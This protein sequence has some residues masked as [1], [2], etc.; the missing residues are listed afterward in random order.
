MLTI[1]QALTKRSP[2]E[3]LALLDQPHQ[4]H[5]LVKRLP[6]EDGEVLSIDATLQ[7]SGGIELLLRLGWEFDTSV[8][9]RESERHPAVTVPAAELCRLNP[10]VQ[11]ALLDAIEIAPKVGSS[12]EL[13]EAVV[14]ERLFME[15]TEGLTP[16]LIRE[17]R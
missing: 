10:T 15:D 13:E 16:F 14:R 12:E 9:L 17:W 7:C 2:E 6:V 5:R 1:R 11:R 4:L 3:L 8:Q